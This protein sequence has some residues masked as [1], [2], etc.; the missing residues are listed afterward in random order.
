MKSSEMRFFRSMAG[1]RRTD[2][3]RNTERRQDLK[4]PI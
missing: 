1:Y 3:K 2:K 4:I